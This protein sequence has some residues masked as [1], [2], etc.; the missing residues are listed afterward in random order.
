[1]RKSRRRGCVLSQ[2]KKAAA[3]QRILAGENVADLARELG[4][5]RTVPYKWQ[6]RYARGGAEA[7]HGRKGRPLGSPNAADKRPPAVTDFDTAKQRIAELE[8]KIGQQELELDFFQRA[9]RQVGK[10]LQPGD[11]PGKKPSTPSS[12]R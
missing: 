10:Q 12:K 2:P 11:G 8:C 7:L 5:E 9:L 1:M 6:R 3:V 4:V